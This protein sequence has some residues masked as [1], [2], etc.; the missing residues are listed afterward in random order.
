[1]H[2]LRSREQSTKRR[3]SRENMWK[4]CLY[5]GQNNKIFWLPNMT[6]T[7]VWEIHEV[8]KGVVCFSWLCFSDADWLGRQT[9]ITW[10]GEQV[11]LEGRKRGKDEIKWNEK[12]VEGKER[13]ECV[14]ISFD[15]VANWRELGLWCSKVG[16]AFRKIC[17]EAWFF[18]A[19]FFLLQKSPFAGLIY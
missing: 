14:Y 16:R 1:M 7:F 3:T 18:S 19:C 5:I 12:M 6:D 8:R 15:N 13:R 11:I 2:T 9:P 4:V 10:C 17:V